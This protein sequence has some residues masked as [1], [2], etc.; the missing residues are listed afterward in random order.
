MTDPPRPLAD[1]L[2]PPGAALAGLGGVRPDLRVVDLD[3]H[4]STFTRRF[5]SEFPDRYV[6]ASGDLA[7]GV[8][9]AVALISEGGPV[10]L[11]G[12][13]EGVVV[14]GFAPIRRLL[15]R[16]LSPLL[17]VTTDGGWT[18]SEPAVLEDVAL[19]RG[20]PGLKVVVPADAR[21]AR[22]ALD[23]LGRTEGPAY[24]R[25]SRELVDRVGDVPFEIGRARE[26]RAGVD[27]AM[28]AVGPP[29][30][31]ALQAAGALAEVGLATRVLDLAS[32]APC[33]EKAI[34]RAARDTGAVLTVEEHQAATGVG[35]LVA[36]LTAEN[37]PVPVR[38]LG[39]PDLPG[40]QG[41]PGGGRAA[42]GL[43]LD[44]VRDEAWELLR[45]KGKVQ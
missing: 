13:A 45:L 42:L 32:I 7:A 33:D 17:L 3:A 38:R 36:A 23:L 37:V 34:L 31:L 5:A 25:L 14:H 30:A 28:M 27:L 18:S 19:L 9:R 2:D 24:I 40:R 6:Q 44:A 20:V 39:V 12:P 29:V 43:T 22:S 15:A 26:L 10:V 1:G 16:R 21:T 11:A 41:P 35:A 8:A 4:G